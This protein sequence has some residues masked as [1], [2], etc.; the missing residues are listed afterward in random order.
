M[1]KFIVH[2]FKERVR[3]IDY[4]KLFSFF[5][6]YP[7]I[8]IENAP[9]DA[10]E[11]SMF[12]KHP[13]LKTDVRFVLSSSSTVREIHQI[14]PQ[15]LDVNFRLEMSILTPYYIANKL[16]EITRKLVEEFSFLIFNRLLEDVIPYKIDK[17]YRLFELTKKEFKDKFGYKLKAY[18]HYPVTKLNDCLKYIDEQYELQQYYKEQDIYVPNY[19]FVADE[20]KQ[21]YLAMEWEEGNKTVFPP[22]LDYIYYITGLESKVLPYNE[23]MAKIE[24]FSENVPGFLKNTKVTQSKYVKRIVKTLKRAKFTTIDKQLSRIDLNLIID[25]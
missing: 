10:K 3:D 8:T 18:Y 1:E 6:D 2:F 22:H 21:I 11:M 17:V 24:R 16:F 23:V 7:E 4:E 5:K 13:I 15:Y 20:E 19:Y 14:H 9:K 25:L 12:Y